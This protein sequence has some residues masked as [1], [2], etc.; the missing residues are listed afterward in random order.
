MMM[1]AIWDV[2]LSGLVEFDRSFR[3]PYW[4]Y[5]Q[6]DPPRHCQ[7]KQINKDATGRTCG[8]S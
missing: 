4:L 1:T 5:H 7:G 2:A 8:M 3:G 6:H